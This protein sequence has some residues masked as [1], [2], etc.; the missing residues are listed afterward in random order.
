MSYT[1]TYTVYIIMYTVMSIA[2]SNYVLYYN[3]LPW[4]HV[5]KYYIFSECCRSRDI[6]RY[7]FL[8]SYLFNPQCKNTM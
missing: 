7:S 6:L 5:F 1:Y 4:E 3:V 8:F 2:Y